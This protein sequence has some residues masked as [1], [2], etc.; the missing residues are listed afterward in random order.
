MFYNDKN[1]LNIIYT[2]TLK[3]FY[4]F[5]FIIEHERVQSRS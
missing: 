4:S 2:A 5:T 1:G 3:L